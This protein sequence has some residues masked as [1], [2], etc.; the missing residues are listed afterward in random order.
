[1]DERKGF[2]V[3]WAPWRMDYITGPRDGGCFLCSLAGTEPSPDT[4]LLARTPAS[5]VVFNRYPYN[6]GH[7]LVA[8]RRHVAE[9]GALGG[10]EYVELME[11]FRLSLDALGRA[12]SPE[13]FNAGLN[14]GKTAGA[15]LESHL[16]WHIVPRWNG[17][18]NF[19]PVVAGTRVVPEALAATWGKLRPFF[20]PLEGAF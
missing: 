18:T 10:E 2:E 8:P 13:G 5:L 3:V 15:G 9:P 7:L 19:M 14:L 4:L 16:H 12:F 20:A 17:D 11:V 1:M 6:N